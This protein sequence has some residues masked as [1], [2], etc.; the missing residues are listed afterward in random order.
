MAAKGGCQRHPGLF[1]VVARPAAGR[2]LGEAGVEVVCPCRQCEDD[3]AQAGLACCER[4]GG[5]RTSCPTC[6]SLIE[7]GDADVFERMGD[8]AG[9]E[10][11]RER[12]RRRQRGAA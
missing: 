5:D 9:A 2:P 4:H 1:R 11:L 12:A 8:R 10:A 3:R 6:T 7:L